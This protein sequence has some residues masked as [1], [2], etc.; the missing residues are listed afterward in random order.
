MV[1][2][3]HFLPMSGLTT[4]ELCMCGYS[5]ALNRNYP[6]RNDHFVHDVF[7]EILSYIGFW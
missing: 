1:T 4:M 3:S 7:E 2:V 5:A 6:Y